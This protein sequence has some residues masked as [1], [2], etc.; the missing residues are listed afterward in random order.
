MRNTD[1]TGHQ[2][3]NL[4]DDQLDPQ[5]DPHGPQEFMRLFLVSQRRILSYVMVLV[6]NFA[7]AEDIVQESAAVMWEKFG[8]FTPGTD[9]LL[10]KLGKLN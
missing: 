6:P 4:T 1:S 5:R 9:S 3:A 2:G 7:T 8:Q 10:S